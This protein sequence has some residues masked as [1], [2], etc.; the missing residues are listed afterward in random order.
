MPD[1]ST[2][3]LLG[4]AGVWLGGG[5]ILAGLGVLLRGLITGSLGQEKE[6]RDSLA[7]RNESLQKERDAAEA[8]ERKMTGYRDAWRYQAQLARLDAEELAR[9]A[10]VT[11]PPWPD[12]PEAP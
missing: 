10:G 5:G 3:D 6:V 9:K 4:Q 1:E 2:K 11:L 8:A 7:T 12:A